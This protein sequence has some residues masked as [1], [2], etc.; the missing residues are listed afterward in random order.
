MNWS[1]ITP[2]AL[3]AALAVVL[4]AVADRAAEARPRCHEGYQTIQGRS[5]STPYCE[6]EYLAQVARE[7]GSRISADTIRS[8]PNAKRDLCRFIGRDIRINQA[9]IQFQGARGRY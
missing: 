1:R 5:L 3:P 2:L 4:L 7:Y 8:N 6:D 9:C